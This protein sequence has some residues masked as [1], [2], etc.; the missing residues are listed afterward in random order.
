MK[1]MD[2]K[3]ILQKEY[4][5]NVPYPYSFWISSAIVQGEHDLAY[6]FLEKNLDKKGI[7]PDKSDNDCKALNLVQIMLLKDPAEIS[8]VL[9]F[10]TKKLDNFEYKKNKEDYQKTKEILEIE[11]LEGKEKMMFYNVKRKEFDNKSLLQFINLENVRLSRQR[12]ELIDLSVKIADLNHSSNS[13]NSEEEKVIVDTKKAMEEVIYHYKTGLPS[14]AGL[15]D[16]IKQIKERYPWSDSKKVLM[17]LASI[18]TCILGVGLFGLDIYTDIQFSWD[19]WNINRTLG[20]DNESFKATF[21][22]FLSKNDLKFRTRKARSRALESL[23]DL[24]ED[25]D[26]RINETSNDFDDYKLTS[27]IAIC[28]CILPIVI[29]MIVF[30]SMRCRKGKKILTPFELANFKSPKWWGLNIF[31][32]IPNLAFLGKVLPIPAF[33]HL[34]RCYLDIRCHKARSKPDFR[35]KIVQWEKKIRK[36]EAIGKL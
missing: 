9:S 7:R 16:M 12:E 20:K 11:K 19:L 36:H 1:T 31:C 2:P 18:G 32:C 13:L 14:G 5:N 26:R 24:E 29:T 4:D 30:I 8:S 21:I 28:H 25:F 34:Y 3:E 27:G 35:T 22:R 33:T 10:L 6:H 15:R 23:K 17:I